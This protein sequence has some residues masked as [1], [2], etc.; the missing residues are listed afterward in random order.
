MKRLLLFFLFSALFFSCAPPSY[1]P[2]KAPPPPKRITYPPPKSSFLYLEGK[3]AFDRDNTSLALKK[4][5]QF[6]KLNPVSEF[7]DDAMFIVGQ[8]YLKREN[9]YEAL[10]YFQKMEKIFPGSNTIEEAVYGQAYCWYKLKNFKRSKDALERLFSSFPLSD[11]LYVRAQTLKGHLC[12]V[13]KQVVCGVQAYLS[14]RARTANSSERA[15]LDSFIVKV[16]FRIKD[17]GVVEDIIDEHQGDMAG[18]AA[19]VRLAEILTFQKDY[20]KVREILTPSFIEQLPDVLRQKAEGLLAKLKRAFIKKITIGCLLPLTGKRAPFGI[21]AL[22][23][24]LLAA[25]AFQTNPKNL[26]ITLEVR[27]TKGIPEMAAKM[28]R[29]LVETYHVKAIVGPMFLDTTEA[30]VQQLQGIPV[31]LISLSQADGVPELGEHVFRNCLTPAQQ[32]QA[33]VRYLTGTLNIRTAAI[34]FPQTPF[35]LRYMKLF[36]EKFTEAGGEIRGAESYLPTDTDFGTPIKKLIGL[37]YTKER[38]ERGDTP[39][40]EGEKFSPV[41]DFKAL[42]I[43]DTYGKVVLIAPQLAFYDVLGVTLAGIN[44]WDSP[45]LFKEGKQFVRGSVFTD[46]FSPRDP[47]PAVRAFV[48][49]FKAI[50]DETPEILAAQAYDATWILV[51]L[52]KRYSIDDIKELEEK[53]RE[54]TGFHG[55]SGLRYFDVNGEAKRDVIIMTVTRKG[56]SPVSLSPSPSS[57]TV[58]P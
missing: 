37:Y 29:E 18:D 24:T 1:R 17:V 28:A 23:G 34:L 5:D 44:T 47:A 7:T 52:F 45:E 27:D 50:Y 12:V 3:A 6:I 55:V 53:L 31:P 38:W 16:I 10:R 32:I 14:A 57:I 33:L 42:F 54:D 20:K 4:L 40:E 35:G 48:A 46:G 13:E 49:D 36:W 21:R 56:V 19:K 30:A 39:L 41:I 25:E 8:I 51:S 9:P 15:V 43:P 22:K 11:S 26:E 58:S 2:K